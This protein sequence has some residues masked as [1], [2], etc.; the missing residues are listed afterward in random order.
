MRPRLLVHHTAGARMARWLLH[1]RDLAAS[2]ELMLTQ[3]FLAKMLSVRRT[4]LTGVAIP[5]QKA[6]L[7]KYARGHIRVMDVDGLK[8]RSCEC[9]E[10]VKAHYQR[11]FAR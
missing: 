6:G 11:M 7:I 10:T 3:E 8:K 9:Y 2:D 1:M 4:S 5:L